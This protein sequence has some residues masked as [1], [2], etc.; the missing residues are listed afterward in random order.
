MKHLSS[1]ALLTIASLFVAHEAIGQDRALQAEIPF[2]FQ[3]GDTWMPAGEYAVSSPDHSLILFKS[4]KTGAIAE[5]A[6]SPSY[7][8]AIS[9][10]GELVFDRYGDQYFLHRVLCAYHPLNVDVPQG[11]TEKR[12][13]TLQSSLRNRSEVQIAALR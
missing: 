10:R 13:R 8:E 2:N 1:L 7:M 5:V 6:T 11:K 4:I 12:V 9:G 3:V